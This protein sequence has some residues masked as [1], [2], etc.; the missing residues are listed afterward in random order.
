MGPLEGIK[1]LD[2]SQA[3][4][5]PCCTS[6]LAD[7][8]AE[9]IKIENLKGSEMT[10]H[11]N[12]SRKF[13]N[14]NPEIGGDSFW[15]I[16]RNKYSVSLDTRSK[17]GMDI[18]Y[19]LME[20][21]DVVVSNY[22]PGTTKAMGIDY[23]TLKDRFPRII[24]AEIGAFAEKE[25]AEEPAFDAIIQAASGVMDATGEP[26]MPSKVGFSITDVVSGLFLVQGIMFALY[27]REKTGVGQNVDVRMQDAGMYFFQQEA[28]D[29]LG[30][31]DYKDERCGSRSNMACPNGAAKTKDGFI[32]INPGSDKLWKTFCEEIM[33]EPDWITNPKFNNAIGRME[34][35]DEVW[36]KIEKKFSNYTS[37]ELYRKMKAAGLPSSPIVSSKDAYK[38]AKEEG[39]QIVAQVDHPQYGKVDVAGFVINL[40]KTPGEVKKGAPRLGEDTNRVLKELGNYSEEEIKDLESRGVIRTK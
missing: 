10:R 6:I 3:L 38:K 21:A 9:V 32:I 34:N 17:E 27:N 29:L 8:G 33:E 35:K 31:P 18:V 11:V 23:E 14:D 30:D 12:L 22:R 40:S 16:C 13:N 24:C 4:A 7:Y 36:E 2:F 20:N 19:R 37:D 1:V 5:G 15:A 39:R 28:V 26:A 25:R